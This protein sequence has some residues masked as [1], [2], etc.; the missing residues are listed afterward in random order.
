MQ[1]VIF[2][3]SGRTLE[4]FEPQIPPPQLSETS[5]AGRKTA[6]TMARKQS[7]PLSYITKDIA[8]GIAGWPIIINEIFDE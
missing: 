8:G 5:T 4:L 2:T 1:T 6:S 3:V 7:S